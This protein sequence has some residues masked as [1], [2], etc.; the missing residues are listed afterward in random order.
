MEKEIAG[1]SLEKIATSGQCF[2]WQQLAENSYRIPHAGSC[3]YIRMEEPGRFSMSCTEAEFETIWR[4][5][6]DLDTDYESINHRVNPERDPFLHE[7]MRNQY[8]VR[9]LRQDMWEMVITSIITQNRNIPAIR[10]SV[11]LL[12]C[13]GGDKKHDHTGREFYAFPSPAQLVAISD[14]DFSKCK[15]GYRERYIRETA[16]AIYTG[17]MNLDQLEILSDQD[18]M[19]R[20]TEL[21]GVGEKVAACIMLFGMHRLNAFPRDV[22]IL[23]VLEEKYPEGFPFEQYKPYNGVFQQ[24]LFAYYRNLSTKA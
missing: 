17:W 15:L 12:S 18:C 9:I 24:Y 1:L 21:C 2:R 8:G 5:Y 19:K 14:T 3:L 23:R 10:K 6:F 16:E 22:W 11:E 20:L 13:Y 4:A 7:A